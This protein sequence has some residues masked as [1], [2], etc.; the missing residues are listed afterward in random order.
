MDAVTGVRTF[1][2]TT[3][4]ALDRLLYFFPAILTA[5]ETAFQVCLALFF[6]IIAA[7][8]SALPSFLFLDAPVGG[9]DAIFQIAG[10]LLLLIFCSACGVFLFFGLVLYAAAFFAVTA[11]GVIYPFVRED[12]FYLYCLIVEWAENLQR[13]HNNGITNAEDRIIS[14][15]IDHGNYPELGRLTT[16]ELA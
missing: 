13:S 12:L 10:I 4:R 9:N 11:Y 5:L 16:F 2:V 3:V 14:Y 1:C 8:A 6:Y 15:I 7:L